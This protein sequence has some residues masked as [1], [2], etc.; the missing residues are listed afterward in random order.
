MSLKF[1]NLLITFGT[2]PTFAE[3]FIFNGSCFFIA[4]SSLIN[5]KT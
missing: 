2:N 1:P 5:C 3:K 4:R